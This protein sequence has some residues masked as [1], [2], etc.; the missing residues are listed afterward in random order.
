[1]DINSLSL[2]SDEEIE[3]SLRALYEQHGYTKYRMSKFEE[4][5]FYGENKA[6]LQ[7]DRVLTFTDLSGKLMALKPDITLSIVKSARMETEERLYYSENVYRAPEGSREFREIAQIGL[8]CLGRQDAFTTAEVIYLAEKSLETVSRRCLLDVSHMGLILGLIEETGLPSSRRAALADCIGRKN[9]HELRALCRENDVPEALEE[10]L[11][12]LATLY[13]PFTDALERAGALDVNEQTHAALRELGEVFALVQL[14]GGGAH[15]NLDFS[16]VNDMRYYSGVIFQGFVESVPVEIL[17][18]GR[19][20][21][22]L[23][24]FGHDE[25]AIGFALSLGLLERY[26]V[27]EQRYDAEVLLR[28][29]PGAD[30][31]RLALC[32]KKLRE[33]Y[34]SVRVQPAGR[35]E[36]PR[37]RYTMNFTGEG[38]AAFD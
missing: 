3:L 6:F 36:E 35:G 25:G 5:D 27:P 32:A 19:Y 24:R 2:R 34:G 37:C 26:I 8:E 1:M 13:G 38:A 28:Y 33:E 10:K 18:G 4:Y 29:S 22:L 23:R 16:I 9:V 21:N 31:N 17:S 30:L 20:D 7:S 12:M 14:L 11:A 15:I